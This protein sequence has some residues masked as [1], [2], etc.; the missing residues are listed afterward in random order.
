[1]STVLSSIL[2]LG[3]ISIVFCIFF[4]SA[5]NDDSADMQQNGSE[6]AKP[7]DEYT[8]EEPGE[9]KSIAE[10]HIPE[11]RFEKSGY[12]YE[13]TV[14]V[15]GRGF[16][17]GH[18]VEKIGIMDGDK[19]DIVVNTVNSEEIPVTT[20]LKLNT[21]KYSIDNAK[22][23]IKCNLHDLWTVSLQEVLHK[24]NNEKSQ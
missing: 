14:T 21:E 1:M 4:L 13:F 19:T 7:Q 9:W 15:P 12:N 3:K 5:C 18:R 17:A 24:K 16:T 2:F 10:E 23:Y 22:V 8:R 20:V 6:P 11:V